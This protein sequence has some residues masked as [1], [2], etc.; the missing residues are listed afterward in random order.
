MAIFKAAMQPERET[1]HSIQS[2][3]EVKNNRMF[4]SAPSH[5]FI[6]RTETLPH[7]IDSKVTINVFCSVTAYSHIPEDSIPPQHIR[8]TSETPKSRSGYIHYSI[9]QVMHV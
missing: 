9:R 1:N 4:T 3:A 5:A 6:N 7:K 8:Q 2:S